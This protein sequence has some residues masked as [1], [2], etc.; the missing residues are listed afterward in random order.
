MN[1]ARTEQRVSRIGKRLYLVKL[2]G[3]DDCYVVAND[4]TAAYQ[5]VRRW[6]DAHDYGFTKDRQLRSVT[7][8][9]DRD[10]YEESEVRLYI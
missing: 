9:A 3:I 4:A 6:C 8:L 1:E 2:A 10:R 7:L 5:K